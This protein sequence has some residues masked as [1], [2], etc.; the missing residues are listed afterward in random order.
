[1]RIF[2]FFLWRHTSHSVLTTTADQFAVFCF[3]VITEYLQTLNKGE[4]DEI[5]VSQGT[6]DRYESKNLCN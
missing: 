1:M 3:T 6:L 5:G 2:I 4:T